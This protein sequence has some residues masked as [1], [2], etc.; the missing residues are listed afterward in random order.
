LAKMKGRSGFRFASGFRT[1]GMFG[2]GVDRVMVMVVIMAV[3]V[4]VVMCV[5]VGVLGFKAAKPRAECVAKC[6][7]GHV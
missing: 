6:A 4:G 5:I 3:R 2:M 1:V 7:V